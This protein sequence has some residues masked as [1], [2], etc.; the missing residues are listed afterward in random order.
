MHEI[1]LSFE[2]RS[3]LSHSIVYT[4]PCQC[5]IQQYTLP[6]VYSS[7]R[8][9]VQLRQKISVARSKFLWVKP[10]LICH[11]LVTRDF[12]FFLLFVTS[13][14]THH[15]SEFLLRPIKIKFLALEHVAK[16][17]SK[18][19]RDFSFFTRRT[20]PSPTDFK[21]R[22]GLPSCSSARTSQYSSSPCGAISSA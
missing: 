15:Q 2:A 3:I 13:F 7:K 16:D 8:N 20:P 1:N 6:F 10:E 21:K 17:L 12:S 19:A 9:S 22:I 4:R 11:D 18:S 14:T 5:V